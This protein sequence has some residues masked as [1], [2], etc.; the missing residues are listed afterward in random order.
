[1]LVRDRTT[2]SGSVAPSARIALRLRTDDCS[3]ELLPLC[4]RSV[5]SYPRPAAPA[6]PPASHPAR[7]RDPAAPGPATT[8]TAATTGAPIRHAATGHY[9]GGRAILLR[10][11][12]RGCPAGTAVSTTSMRTTVVDRVGG[13]PEHNLADRALWPGSTGRDCDE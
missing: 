1:M 8:T 10:A 2:V 13:G 6:E 9:R 12:T 11:D 7:T 3:A 5:K 4:R